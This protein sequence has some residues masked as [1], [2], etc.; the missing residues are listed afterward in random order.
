MI[1]PRRVPPFGAIR[2]VVVAPTTRLQASP[3]AEQ[4]A[5]FMAAAPVSFPVSGIRVSAD[6]PFL[7]LA[8]LLAGAAFAGLA[9]ALVIS[10]LPGGGVVA[11]LQILSGGG[12]GVGGAARALLWISAHFALAGAVLQGI[13][14]A[15]GEKR[16]TALAGAIAGVAWGVAVGTACGLFVALVVLVL[17]IGGSLVAVVGNVVWPGAL[18]PLGVALQ[19]ARIG[20]PGTSPLGPRGPF[21]GSLLVAAAG[22]G[23]ALG[24][25]ANL[26]ALVR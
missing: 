13:L 10:A 14:A 11:D 5:V 21:R 16:D 7:S 4:Q 9:A 25:I 23:L 24:A 20:L 1:A 8:Y 12:S 17:Q 2:V 22:I 19:A 18:V 26:D 3:F 15:G 6:R